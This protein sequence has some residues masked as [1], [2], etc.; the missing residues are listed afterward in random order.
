MDYELLYILVA[1]IPFAATLID[2]LGQ[3]MS[4]RHHIHHDTYE[5]PAAL[6]HSLVVVMVGMGL[7]GVV[8]GIVIDATMGGEHFLSV[9]AFFAMFE[10]VLFVLWFSMRRY[11][12]VTYQD[13]MVV[14]PFVGKPVSVAYADITALRWCRIRFGFSDVSIE[15][16]AGGKKVAKLWNGIDTDQVLMTTGRLDALDVPGVCAW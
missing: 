12:V 16:Y 3:T 11:K 10:V 9:M 7:L 5:P 4:E 14:T 8:T 1:G 13:H 6:F 2:W 15:V